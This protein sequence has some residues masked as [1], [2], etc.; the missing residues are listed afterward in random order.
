MKTMYRTAILAMLLLGCD[1]PADSAPPAHDSH[2]EAA[3][4]ESP[5]FPKTIE[6]DPELLAAG[7]ISLVIAQSS[8]SSGTPRIPGEV[9]SSID[10]AA[11]ISTLTGGRIS[12]LEVNVGDQVE[13]S[14]VLAWVE[15]PE[16]GSA[17]AELVS[18]S[19]ML[20]MEQGRFD[21][22]E[23]LNQAK[24]T[25][26]AAVEAARAGLKAAESS[27]NAAA[28]R[29][30][31]LGASGGSGARYP[32]RTP[33]A[34]V[35]TE[36]N[37]ILGEAI[38]AGTALFSVIAPGRI[39]VVARFPEGQR[40]IPEEGSK[41]R[42]VPRGGDHDSSCQA[43]VE[44]NTKVVEPHTRTVLVRLRPEPECSSLRPGSY[45]EVH[46][47]MD[48]DESERGREGPVVSVRVPEESVVFVREQ[49]YVFVAAEPPG[50]Y[51]TREVA[52]EFVGDGTAIVHEGVNV[53]ERVV[54]RG[55]IL[56]KGEMLKNVLGGA[57]HGH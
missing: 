44:T 2:E 50:H 41:V 16:V 42:L 47:L 36:R 15:S 35:V 29:L 43:S 32:L 20:E 6:V 1:H 4:A 23:T 40:G 10:G 9:V 56:L 34:G 48:S 26:Q 14:Q 39:L 27:R 7:R 30:T 13:Q 46:P 12:S 21:R 45:V 57:G 31:A 5:E 8:V 53:G 52:A 38:R 25:S 28:L 3:H 11:E 51:E 24:A 18:A 22:Q 37:A 33:I 17:R 55:T 54:E 19:A 49:H